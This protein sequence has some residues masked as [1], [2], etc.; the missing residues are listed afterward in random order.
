MNTYSQYW[1]TD[2]SPVILQSRIQ[3]LYNSKY[4]SG[5]LYALFAG[6]VL[7]LFI[8]VIQSIRG[9]EGEFNLTNIL[10]AISIIVSSHLPTVPR[11][12]PMRFNQVPF[13]LGFHVLGI[14]STL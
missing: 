6:E 9:T 2:I 12:T 7:G 1:Y 8:V 14:C 10:S 5:F 13:L 3:A 11:D 4:V